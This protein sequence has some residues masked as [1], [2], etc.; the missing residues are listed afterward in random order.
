MVVITR[1]IRGNVFTSGCRNVAF[2]VN[3]EGHNHAGFAGLIASRYWPGLAHPGQKS[4]GDVMT[5]QAE[6]Y[7]FHA[8]VCHFAEPGGFSQTP[9]II[10]RCLDA[11]PVADDLEI[12][13][14]MVG[15]GPVGQMAG[16]DVDAILEGIRRSRKRVAVYSL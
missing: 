14:V 11:L 10:T 1:T 15:G 6:P 2:G 4:L 8:L 16:A 5:H 3:A 9:T 7:T 13:C 12:A